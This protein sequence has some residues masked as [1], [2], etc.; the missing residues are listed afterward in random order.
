MAVELYKGEELVTTTRPHAR[1]LVWPIALLMVLSALVGV[2]IAVVPLEN[3]PW[4]Q[5]VV[6]GVGALLALILVVRPVLRWAA[7][8]TTLTT[9][10]L[11]VR[12]GLLRRRSQDLPLNRIVDVGYTRTAGDWGFGSGTLLITT[13]A[14]HRVAFDN[15]P[16]IKAMHEAVSELATATIPADPW[17]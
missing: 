11:I 10:R 6:A 7:T 17:H 12:G 4:G 14:G 5:D 9:D 1:V 2:G 13:L 15:L 8:S 3:R 16:R